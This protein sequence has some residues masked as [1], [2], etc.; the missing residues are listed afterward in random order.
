MDEPCDF[1]SARPGPYFNLWGVGFDPAIGQTEGQPFVLT[2]F[3]TPSLMI[4]P[5]IEKTEIGVSARRVA[6]TMLSVNGNIWML[7][8]V[9]H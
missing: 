9:D 7:T 6:L 3:D 2:D 4:S 8:N 1:I 5:H